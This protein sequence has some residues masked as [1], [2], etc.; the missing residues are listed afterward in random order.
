MIICGDA[1]T[2]L[3]KLPDESVHCCITSPPYNL[4]NQHH[5][6]K[7]RHT[8]Y[9]D[10]MPEQEYQDW[11]VNILQELY[12]VMKKEGSLFYNHKNRIKNGVSITPYRWICKSTWVIKQEL[13]WFNR[14]SNFDKIRFYPMT[15]RIYWLAK[16][17]KTKIYNAISHHDVFK[18]K[19]VGTNER[20][21]RRFP[22]EMVRDILMC[23]PGAKIILDPFFGAGTV[24]VVAKQLGRDFIGIE[25]N[26]E[27]CKMAEGRIAGVAYQMP[28]AKW[29]SQKAVEQESP[30]L[31]ISEED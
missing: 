30:S 5:T 8:P 10:N 19:T 29:E 25:L 31:K 13:V 7:K 12:R 20:H 14:S 2:E 11:Q 6:N 1:L 27:Y 4:G 26:A 9:E 21:T 24:G 22:E 18:W 3:R 23:L 15:E 16:S 28:L 17:N